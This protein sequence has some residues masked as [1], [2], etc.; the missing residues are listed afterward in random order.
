MGNIAQSVAKGVSSAARTAIGVITNPKKAINSGLNQLQKAAKTVASAASNA[1]ANI[2][3]LARQGYT[4]AKGVFSSFNSYVSYR[5]RQIKMTIQNVL[6]AT[7]AATYVSGKIT[8]E[9][10]KLNLQNKFDLPF[11]INIEYTG[12]LKDFAQ[13]GIGIAGTLGGAA[14]ALLGGG[15]TVA[16]GGTAAGATVPIAWEGVAI[17]GTGLVTVGSALGNMFNVS[18]SKTARRC[19]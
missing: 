18:I 9:R 7:A 1:A 19:V 4:K 12:E 13:L 16:S 17:A 5:T 3:S 6:C 8:W 10:T 2:D 15:G 14:I 11:D